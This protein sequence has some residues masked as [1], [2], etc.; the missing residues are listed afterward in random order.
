M[1]N[2]AWEINLGGGKHQM[3]IVPPHP[4]CV[5]RPSSVF[6]KFVSVFTT[7]CKL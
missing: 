3:F 4:M 6:V 5:R 7:I 1:I 2:E